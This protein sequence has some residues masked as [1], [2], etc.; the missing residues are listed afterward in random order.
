L[1]AR[2]RL[3][4]A[5]FLWPTVGVLVVTAVLLLARHRAAGALA[6]WV[7][8]IIVLAPVSGIAHAGHQLAHDR[9]SYLSGLGFAVLAGA[10]VM[11]LG[12][13]GARVVAGSSAPRQ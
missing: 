4:D 3:L 8:S 13:A 12:N 6:A 2:I 11:W 1:L 9:Y 10:G 5:E 7:H